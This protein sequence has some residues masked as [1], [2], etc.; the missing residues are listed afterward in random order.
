MHVAYRIKYASVTMPH[1]GFKLLDVPSASEVFVSRCT[2][3]SLRTP[4]ALIH[5]GAYTLR[6]K[7]ITNARFNVHTQIDTPS[8]VP[9]NAHT[10]TCR[11]GASYIF[12]MM[13]LHPDRALA[14]SAIC[15]MLALVPGIDPVLHSAKYQL[16][17]WTVRLW[18][19]IPPLF[20]R[21]QLSLHCPPA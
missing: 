17:C 20:E 9:I 13:R 3:L 19:A 11:S 14:S 5:F 2:R 7:R 6:S 12:T 15:T 8:G 1:P 18:S 21:R 16:G 10:H 4:C